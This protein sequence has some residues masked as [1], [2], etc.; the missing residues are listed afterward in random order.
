MRLMWGR[1]G[2]RRIMATVPKITKQI[3]LVK[4]IIPL[5]PDIRSDCLSELSM[6]GPSTIARTRGAPDRKRVL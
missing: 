6:S 1:S 5:P 3:G 4:K 2:R